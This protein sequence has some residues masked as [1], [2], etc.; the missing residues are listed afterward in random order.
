MCVLEWL[1]S[2]DIVEDVSI[3][4]TFNVAAGGVTLGGG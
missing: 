1:Y 4:N 2:I 3:P